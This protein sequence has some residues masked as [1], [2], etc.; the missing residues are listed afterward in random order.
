MILS[1]NRK[2]LVIALALLLL[3]A[4][5]IA[6]EQVDVERSGNKVILDGTVYYI[7]VVK[8]GQTLYAISRAYHISQKEIAVE[9]PGV[10][11]GLRVGQALKIPVEPAMEAEI[12]TSQLEESELE[13]RVHEVQPGETLYR[14]ARN[15]GVEEEALLQANQGLDIEN[16]QPG[17]RLL[18]P[19]PADV[20]QQPVYN[21]EGFAYHRVKRRETL[22]S[23]A[24]YYGVAVE[25]IREANPELGWGGP[26]TGQRIRIPLPQ[27]IDHPETSFDS[28]MT[29][30]DGTSESEEPLE[31]YNY[32]ELSFEH[33]D[34]FHTY[35]IAFFIPFDFQEP[36]PLD[37][38]LKDVN[39]IAR[40]NR[41]I[42]R[43]RMEQTIPQA[44]SFL[45]FFQGS[46][47]A[48]DSLR[49]TGMQLDL[50]FYD[51][52]RSMDH[53]LSIILDDDLEDFD[54]FIGPFYP[55]NLE[56]VAAFAEKHR[57]PVIT[58]F[59]NEM[60][61]VRSNPFLF[62]PSPS[63]EREYREAAKIIASKHMYNIV[64]V[65]E[66]DSL[67]IEKHNYFKELI[68]DGFDDY[69]PSEPVTFKEIV[70][71]L[72]H[73]DEI[74]H[75]LSKDKKNLVVV[76]TRNEALASR[77]VSSL[78]FQLKDYDIEIIGTPFWTEFSSIDFRYFHELN[79]IFYSSFWV[80]YLDPGI[81]RFMTSYRNFFYNEPLE[82]SRKGL[83]YG[84]I[85]YDMTFY[86]IN[87]LRLYGSRFILS[88]DRYEPRMIQE[89]FK[90]RRVSSAGGYEN[91]QIA[92]Y[93]FSP[94]MSIHRIEVPELP[95]RSFFF[96]PIEDLRRRRF[97]FRERNLDE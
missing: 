37:S 83:N 64:Y 73:T 47:M 43:Y 90:F 58:P 62:Q 92:F 10:I 70:Q 2:P 3:H 42:E 80:D 12:D 16:L 66:E 25:E 69:R 30:F 11:S 39:S 52:R 63:L 9:N 7:H 41:I 91:E 51:T 89:P 61:L 28:V 76:P 17:Q 78:Y 95:E 71:K 22:Y 53:T 14:I 75:S 44:V 31:D 85:G 49:Q 27:V 67:D 55:F 24:R 88:M 60:N 1:P 23:I 93:Q 18:I 86:F 65:R 82:T 57:I 56:I 54:L 29:D 21:E 4:G 19:G 45:E 5:L 20:V 79:L 94:D 35:K 77:V 50:R 68:F 74:I 32:E 87:A 6:Q 33:Y 36:E 15:Y 26:K 46:L 34:P 48:I 96:R 84:I 59:Y 81:D 72:E 8:P 13:G 97:L 38:L 40:R